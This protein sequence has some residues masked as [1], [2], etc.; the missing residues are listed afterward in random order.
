MTLQ[1]IMSLYGTGLES[2]IH[3]MRYLRLRTALSHYLM[4]EGQGIATTRRM[5]ACGA[6]PEDAIRN[7]AAERNWGEVE[8]GAD[9]ESGGYPDL[10]WGR[11]F[12]AGTC[13]FKAAGCFVPGGAVV[14]WWK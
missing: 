11:Y 3:G 9:L 13:G 2:D 12:Q 8:M 7:L 10:M 5:L 6:T 1:E 4:L 14:L